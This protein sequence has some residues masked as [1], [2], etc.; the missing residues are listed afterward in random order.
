MSVLHWTWLV[1]EVRRTRKGIA[2]SLKTA[3][4]QSAADNARA[5]VPTSLTVPAAIFF[6]LSD[7]AH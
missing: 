3:Q 4:R 6:E 7:L 2:H 5:F 1:K